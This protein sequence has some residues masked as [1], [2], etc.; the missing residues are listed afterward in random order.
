MFFLLWFGSDV[1]EER[2]PDGFFSCPRCGGQRPCD[3]VRVTR[4][5]KAYSLLPIWKSTIAEARACQTCG[6]REGDRLSLTPQA[7]TWCCPRCRNVNPE[8][9]GTCL[10][11][12]A[13]R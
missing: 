1:R 6:T 3:R 11:C 9:A 8:G 7:E 12:G 10:G 4:T 13:S 5:V 2:L